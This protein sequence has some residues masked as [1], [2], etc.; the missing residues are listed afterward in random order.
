MGDKTRAA[1]EARLR[2]IFDRVDTSGDGEISVV[3][4]VKALR[5]DDGFA[6]V[7][8]FDEAT[9]VRQE[10][11]TKDQLILALGALDS[12][13]DK[14]ISWAEFRRVALDGP[15]TVTTPQKQLANLA[16]G[17]RVE[18]R[19]EAGDE[20]YA[21]VIEAAHEDGSYDVL[22]D[23]GD[24]EAHVAADLVKREGP[25]ARRRPFDSLRTSRGRRA[26]MSARGSL[27]THYHPLAAMAS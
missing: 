9:R 18:A 16:V 1:L 2:E 12:D 21:G 6:E 13:G 15:E 8:G 17:T 24:R 25:V 14:K 5:K 23:D 3:E 11:G 22:Y 27:H 26:R 4:A 10:D 20:W 7:L 19:Y